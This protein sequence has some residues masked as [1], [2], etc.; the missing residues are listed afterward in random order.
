MKSQLQYAAAA[1]AIAFLPTSAS[2]TGGLNCGIHDANLDFEFEALYNYAGTSP[3]MQIRGEFAAKSPKAYPTLKKFPIERGDL[4]QQWFEAKDLKLQ[5]YRETTGDNVPH[6]AVKLT[7]EAVSG[8]DEI[9][10]EGNYTL[11]VTPA[12]ADSESE[13]ITLNGK[14]GCSAG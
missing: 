7:I 12:V 4:I 2:A 13:L 8:D 6:A 11:V 9:G 10:Y 3:L 14:V 5:F 1:F